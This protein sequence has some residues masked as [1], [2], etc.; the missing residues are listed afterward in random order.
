MDNNKKLESEIA[1]YAELAKENKNIDVAALMISA[2]KNQ[3]KN[4]VSSRAKKWAYLISI[5][6][7]PLGLF[8][9]LRY[10]FGEQDD[11]VRVAN[12]CLFLTGISLF[13]FYI[14]AK[15]FLSSSGTSLQEVEQITPA[16]IHELT[17]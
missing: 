6:A 16:Q 9:A 15:V 3:D 14:M 10:Y 11:A 8:F 12:I 4:L 13:A 1:E 5:G 2:I 17:Q 7:P